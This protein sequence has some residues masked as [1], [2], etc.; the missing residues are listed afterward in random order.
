MRRDAVALLSG[1]DADARNLFARVNANTRFYIHIVAM[2]VKPGAERT[3]QEVGA[4]LPPKRDFSEGDGSWVA[5]IPCK[6][7]GNSQG[8]D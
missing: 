5:P 8:K 7:H 6:G 2:M 4:E 3:S 1:G